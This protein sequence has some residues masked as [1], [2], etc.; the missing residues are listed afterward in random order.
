MSSASTAERRRAGTSNHFNVAGPVAPYADVSRSPGSVGT[1]RP[2]RTGRAT[3]ASAGRG[4]GAS[5]N[6]APRSAASISAASRARGCRSRDSVT[7]TAPSAHKKKPVNGGSARPGTQAPWR[8]IKPAIVAEP[9]ERG[10]AATFRLSSPPMKAHELFRHLSSAEVRE[11]VVRACEDDGVPDKIAGAVLTFQNIPLR[12]FERLPE[13]TRLSLVRRTLRDKRAADLSLYVLSAAL[14]RTR[15]RADRGV[16]RRRRPPPRRAEP[17]RRGGDPG[18]AGEEGRRRRGRRAGRIRRPGRRALPARL[19]GSARRRLAVAR[20]AARRRR[21]PPP[22]GPLGRLR[23]SPRRPP[24]A[25]R[26]GRARP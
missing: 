13:G 4:S 23:L 21:A 5:G 8:T 16:S 22:G 12:R 11:V 26:R 20:R 9:S 17:L 18:A 15:A 1:A 10:E 14:V 3:E 7:G 6:P 24:A 19:R 2:C 25:R